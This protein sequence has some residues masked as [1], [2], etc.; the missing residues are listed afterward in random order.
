MKKSLIYS[1]V[2]LSLA[3]S[4][5]ATATEKSQEA[6]EVIEVK[7]RA[8]TFYLDQQT[9]V[10]TKVDADLLDIPLSAQVLSK[11]LIIDQAA[12]DITDLYRSIAGVSEFSYSGVTFRGFRDDGNVFY[13][14]VR[15]DPFSGFSVPQLFNVERVEVLK[16]PAAAIY[17]G[18]EPGGMINYVTKKP[19]FSSEKNLNLTLGNFALKGIS[20]DI[21]D[22]IT[23]DLAYRFGA[24]YEAQDSFRNNADQENI[25]VAGGLLYH[26]DEATTVDF[27]F[28]YIVQNLGGNRLRGVPVDDN[29]NF[30]VDPSYNANEKFDFQDMKALVLQS[31]LKHDFSDQL[32]SNVTVR[33]MDNEREQAYHE[34][35]SW[36]DVNGDDKADINDRTIRREYRDQYRANT[37]LSLTVDFVY[38]TTL[39]D[40]EHQIL[41]GGDFH[42]I[43]TDY[44]Y[45]RARYEKDGVKNLNIFDLNYGLTDPS[46]YKLKDMN[47]DG[48]ERT[49]SSLYVQDMVELTEQ[50]MLMVG[51]RFDKFEETDSD[52]G[53]TSYDDSDVSYRAGLTYKPAADTSLYVNYSQSFKPVSADDFEESLGRI[54]PTTGNQIE[55]GAKKEWFDGRILTTIA[56]YQIEKENL[57]QSNPDFIDS[58]ETPNISPI[59]N[60]GLVESDGAEIVVVGD[61]FEDLSVTA[62]YAYNDTKIVEGVDRN[63]LDSNKFVNAPKHQAGLWF[64]YNIEQFDSSFAFGADYVS[65]Q[66]SFDEQRVK[67]Y[68]VFDVSWTTQFDDVLLSIN[69]NNV[70]DKEY[71]VSGF[72]KR[73]GHFPG[74]PREVVAQLAYS[75]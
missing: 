58:D 68:T 21:T 59:R 6:T 30:L 43:E 55:I 69:V 28:D 75:F 62:N 73:N 49:R 38:E 25:E 17:G 39:A 22:G 65:E 26:I 60:F 64:R 63:S 42:D 27:T 74:A 13:D 3:S 53:S 11:Q 8:Q 16:G 4:Y 47:R 61:I 14:G 51:A 24:F 10:G 7:G 36:V 23:E 5:T 45:F 52:K 46:T 29:G 1:A 57:V 32:S 41:F 12:R 33:Y 15:G 2:M 37:E 54:E 9:T 19:K 18:G 67:P 40:M 71:A 20:A 56:F 34:S 31:N 72:S 44:D 48:L 70:F 35:R 50:W 66:I